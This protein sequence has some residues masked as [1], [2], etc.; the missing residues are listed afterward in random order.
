MANLETRIKTSAEREQVARNIIRKELVEK[1]EN[2]DLEGIKEM[3]TLIADESKQ[4]NSKPRGSVEVRNDLGQ[5]LLSIAAQND[6]EALAEFLLTYWKTV[7]TDRWDLSEGEVSPEAKI[8]KAN[9]NSRDLKGWTCICISVFHDS[10]KVL[11]LLLEH[12]GDPNIRSSYNKNAWDLSKDE[13]DAAEK[14][15]KSHA[16]IRQILEEFNK[17]QPG[18]KIFGNGEV[19]KSTNLYDGLEKDGTA[20]VMNIEMN[21]ELSKADENGKKGAGKGKGKSGGGGGGKGK[22]KGKK[23]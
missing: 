17:T 1:A 11:R 7:D 10:R 9:P 21:N 22:D 18:T 2:G 13:L 12:G 8:F 15:V 3:L 6:N 19:V 5:S 20:M 14:V 23:K 4:T 16:D